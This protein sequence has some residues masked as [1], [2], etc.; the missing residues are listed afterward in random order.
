MDRSLCLL[1]PNPNLTPARPFPPCCP[2]HSRNV[3]SVAGAQC[4]APVA[5]QRPRW[6]CA[7]G[8]SSPS[9]PH[10]PAIIA[11]NSF[12]LPSRGFSREQ[13]AL[14][15]EHH[16]LAELNPTAEKWGIRWGLK[17]CRDS[18]ARKLKVMRVMQQDN[19]TINSSSIDHTYCVT[20]AGR[21]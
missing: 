15:F 6:A 10:A 3:L 17:F 4:R 1:A 21:R 8:R 12:Y 20:G 5:S 13:R 14:R 11:R 16:Q 18:E 2:T 19:Q 7:S 9:K